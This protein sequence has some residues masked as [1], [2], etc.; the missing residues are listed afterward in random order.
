MTALIAADTAD[1]SRRM[2]SVKLS[3]ADNSRL[4]QL[5][6]D[7]SLLPALLEDLAGIESGIPELEQGSAPYRV[8]GT[9]SCW[10]PAHPQRILCPGFRVGPDGSGLTLAA[11]GSDGF[12]FPAHRP[13]ELATLIERAIAPL[14]AP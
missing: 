9:A 4:D 2:C 1:A 10:M 12:A 6:L 5:Y 8:E 14:P 13:A 7:E 11:Y 3:L